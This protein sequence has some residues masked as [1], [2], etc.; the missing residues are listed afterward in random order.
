M[1]SSSWAFKNYKKIQL[2]TIDFILC[3]TLLFIHKRKNIGSIFIHIKQMYNNK[4]W[5]SLTRI[6]ELWQILIDVFGFE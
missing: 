6:S 5:S 2:R 1:F 4:Y 3:V